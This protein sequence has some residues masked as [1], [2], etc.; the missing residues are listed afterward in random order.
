MTTLCEAR[1]TITSGVLPA[2]PPNPIVC[3]IDL[4]TSV[5][6][7]SDRRLALSSNPA[8]AAKLIAISCFCVASTKSST[9]VAQSCSLLQMLTIAVKTTIRA[10]A[11][12]LTPAK[13]AIVSRHSHK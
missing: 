7:A 13:V 10:P 8:S 5:S 1:F 6:F 9:V 12:T 4:G 3:Q 11:R 2:L